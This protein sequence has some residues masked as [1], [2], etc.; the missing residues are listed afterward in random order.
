[1]LAFSIAVSVVVGLGFG[2]LPGLTV[3]KTDVQQALR[4]AGNAGTIGTAGRFL[5]H[6]LVIGEISLSIVLL[7]GTGLLFR[8]MLRLQNQPLGFRTDRVVAT[9]IGLPRIRYQ[10]NNDVIHFFSRVDENLRALPAYEAVGLGYPLPLGGNHFWT[11]FTV[12]GRN[13]APG[14]YD[15]AS[16]RFMDSGF[17]RVMDIPLLAGRNFTDADDANTQPVAIVSESFAR[18][19]WPGEDAVGKY[20]TILRD[21]PV[22]RRVVGVVA[23]VKAT[24]EEDP[25]PSMYVSFKQMSFP[26]MQIVL[27]QRDRPASVTADVRRA[28]QSVDPLQPVRYFE[29]MES[30]VRESLDPWRFALSLLGGLAGLAGLHTTVGLFAVLSYLARERTKELGIRM[31]IGAPRS[32]IMRLVLGQSVKMALFGTSIGLAF[33]F[34]VVRL[35]NS[36]MYAI[37]PNDPATFAVVAISVAAIS[38]VAAYVPARRAAR[39]E[40]L[41]ALREE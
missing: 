41:A 32:S 24:I 23:D 11:S 28:V 9:W 29:S 35:M 22:P 16:L 25:P 2:L 13:T 3:I 5:R 40:P 38:I 36:M 7:I 14:E 19:Y 6:A 31:A 15:S 34:A 30:M 1:V 26:S 33:T 8:S 37:R 10:N 21:T 18:K 17:L 39:I 4:K 12:A 27:L 20:I